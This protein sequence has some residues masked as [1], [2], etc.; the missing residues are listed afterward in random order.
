[1]NTI[2][3]EN[4]MAVLSPSSQYGPPFS[5]VQAEFKTINNFIPINRGGLSKAFGFSLY[6]NCG[7]GIVTGMHRYLKSD[8]TSLFLVSHGNT[9]YKLVAGT[10]TSV[11]TAL[12]N[13]AY[14][15]FTN[16][17]D[18]CVICD[19]TNTPLRFNGTTVS[20]LGG[21]PPSGAQQSIF[22]KNRLWMFSA[23]SNPSLLYY[24]DPN[25]IENGYSSNFVQCDVNDGQK[26][27]SI[28]EFFIPGELEPTI[29]VGKERSVGI[30]TGNGTTADPFTFKKIQ[31][32]IGI[33]GFRQIVQFGQDIAFLTH[34]G[35]SSYLTSV[36]NI[37]LQYAF[38]S[39]KI[40]NQFTGLSTTYL[41]TALSWHD[42][43]NSRIAFAV[44]SGTSHYPNLIWYYDIRLKCW[45]QQSGFYVTSVLVDTD[46]SIYTG[47]Q[48]GKI[49]LHSA[50]D[51]SYDGGAINATIQTPY[52]DFFEPNYY[53]RIVRA[54]I[55][56]RGNGMYNVGVGCNLDYGTRL[57]SSHTIDLSSGAYTWNG[58][59]WTSDPNTYQWGGPPLRI[60]QFYPKG[61]FKNIAFTI[62][63]SGADQP[64]DVFE[65]EFDVE[66]LSQY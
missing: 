49:Y 56:M 25:D 13:N 35:V 58:G 19:G 5:Q 23:T 16:A 21:S 59:L 9:L 30:V 41:P 54:S 63:Q 4:A 43:K 47:D 65:L 45:Y 37:N 39:E 50:S 7:T 1:M 60:K 64:V 52:L 53:K 46:G 48:N 10:L 61:I 57:G 15:D 31:F 8:G 44:A 27:T 20:T 12:Q 33:P 66:Y 18:L 3:E 14:T 62:T 55:S 40:R 28:A 32:D 6:K 11:S 17:T 36:Q 51:Y 2:A 24:S 29:L 34:K 42:Y 38:L 22:Y 26:I